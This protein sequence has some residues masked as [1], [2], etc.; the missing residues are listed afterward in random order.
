MEII[1]IAALVMGFLLGGFIIRFLRTYLLN[2][3]ARQRLN[4]IKSLSR[5]INNLHESSKYQ[6]SEKILE[7]IKKECDLISS[8][9]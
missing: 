6:A 7:L 9:K 8:K 4:N 5:S 1:N 3:E 2:M